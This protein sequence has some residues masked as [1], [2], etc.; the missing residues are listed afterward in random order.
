MCYF[1]P[2]DVHTN[3]GDKVITRVVIDI[4]DALVREGN[5][6]EI[7]VTNTWVNRLIGDQQPG[8]K[9]VRKVSRPSG[10]LGGKEYSAGRHTFATFDYY[11]PDSPLQ[12]A[13]LFGPVTLQYKMLPADYDELINP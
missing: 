11:K 1:F 2:S 3:T 6:L 8:D 12:P 7:H 10:L 9:G 5:Q 13:G 4:T